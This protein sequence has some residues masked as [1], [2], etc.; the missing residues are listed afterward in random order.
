MA[1]RDGTFDLEPSLL[2][3]DEVQSHTNLIAARAHICR[4]KGQ[5]K[6]YAIVLL[7]SGRRGSLFSVELLLPSACCLLLPA[8]AREDAA[9]AAI[10]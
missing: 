7:L 3:G 10:I 9:A 4:G 5:D 6:V 1:V 2:D 8:A